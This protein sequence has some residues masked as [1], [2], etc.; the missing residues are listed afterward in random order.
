MTTPPA[1]AVEGGKAGSQI[2]SE[3][4]QNQSKQSLTQR[5]KV[6]ATTNAPAEEQLIKH[7]EELQSHSSTK[8]R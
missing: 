4:A 8:G 6:F 1:E 2:Q 5:G 7:H 3:A